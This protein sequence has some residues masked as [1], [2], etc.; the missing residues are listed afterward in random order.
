MEIAPLRVLIFDNN[1]EPPSF[2]SSNLVHWV[3]KTTPP[4]TE[5]IVRR[6]PHADLPQREGFDAVVLSGS[7]TSCLE[8]QEPWIAPYDQW[9]TEQIQKGTPLLGICYGH[10]TLARCLNKMYGK[11][12]QLRKSEHPELGWVKINFEARSVLWTGLT[13]GFYT[14]ESHY[15][16]VSELPPRS[17]HIA[18][19]ERCLIQGFEG[20]DRPY[21]GVQFHPEYFVEEAERSLSEKLKKGIQK[22]WILNP[23]KGQ[24]LYDEKVPL[25]LFNNFF[26]LAQEHKR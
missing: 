11:V 25:Q 23:G 22:D 20:V 3:L 10:Q 7:I 1:R 8:E 13:D 19:S 15:E 17:K 9:V 2:G 4:G 14:Y 6:P 16:E 5:V 24:A 26:A 18:S 21:F 12:P